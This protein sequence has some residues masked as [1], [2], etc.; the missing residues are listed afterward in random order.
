M[1]QPKYIDPLTDF[2]F[3]HLFGSEPNKDLLIDMLNGILRGH[4]V[5]VDLVYNRNEYVGDGELIGSVIFD[6]LCTGNDGS[7][8]LIE[9]QRTE[10]SH[11]KRRM[12]YYSSKLIADQAP[13]GRRAGWN[14][15]ISEVYVIV[16][17]DGF[18]MP[19]GSN[20]DYLHDI[21]LCDRETG[22]VFYDELGFLYIELT[23]F[24]K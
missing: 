21:Y 5:I 7:Q 19:G 11:L 14:Y 18:G 23:N 20:D 22:E 9:V 6:L 4:K 16:L 1:N 12:L 15:A 13:R 24:V 2:S 8:F 10:Q 17:M 3:K